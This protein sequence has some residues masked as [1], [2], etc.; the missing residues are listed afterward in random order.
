MSN[1]EII[2]SS[3]AFHHTCSEQQWRY[4]WT[5]LPVI[6]IIYF[7]K[8]NSKS[9]I[10]KH[11]QTRLTLEIFLKKKTL[12]RKTLRRKRNEIEEWDGGKLQREIKIISEKERVKRGQYHGVEKDIIKC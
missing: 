1:F 8:F 11:T 9:Q 10:L 4:A 12:I 3:T 6:S 5:T 7:L 2:V